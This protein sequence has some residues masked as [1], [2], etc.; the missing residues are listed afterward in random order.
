M[1]PPNT[2]GRDFTCKT[3]QHLEFRTHSEASRTGGE[4]DDQKSSAEGSA[5][6][7]SAR[8]SRP[9]IG[10]QSM[11]QDPARRKADM[12]AHLTSLMDDGM[13]VYCGG[14]SPTS[15]PVLRAPIGASQ[16]KIGVFAPLRHILRENDTHTA[17]A[18]GP[19]G[20]HSQSPTSTACSS[21]ATAIEEAA[22]CF[23]GRGWPGEHIWSP[24][25]PSARALLSHATKCKQACVSIR[26][27][28]PAQRTRCGHGV[29]MVWAW[30]GICAPAF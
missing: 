24:G 2:L 18:K 22:P 6:N 29:R 21:S 7:S 23:S 13:T 20:A 3:P 27:S 17:T 30:A 19:I 12:G 10:E 5:L 4:D 1:R 9:W 11:A 26:Q 14:G 8:Q 16:R 25:A 28:M 15:I